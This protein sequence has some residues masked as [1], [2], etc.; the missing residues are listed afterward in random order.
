M[1]S[2]ERPSKGALDE[3]LHVNVSPELVDFALSLHLICVSVHQLGDDLL[4][5]DRAR[6][7]LL[8]D[9]SVEAH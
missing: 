8:P 3:A 6:V 9:P 5:T 1:L 7:V 4:A 2:S